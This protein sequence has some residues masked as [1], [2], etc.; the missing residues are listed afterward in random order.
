MG[1]SPLPTPQV[2]LEQW[3][4]H[5]YGWEGFG[6]GCE[7]GRKEAEWYFGAAAERRPLLTPNIVIYNTKTK[8][9]ERE[10]DQHGRND[11]S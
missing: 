11:A 5:N 7:R 4:I 8:R 2:G 1:E 9:K 3:N 10:R 6:R